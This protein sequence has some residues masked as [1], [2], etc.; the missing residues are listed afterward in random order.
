MTF[1]G[2]TALLAAPG[3]GWSIDYVVYETTHPDLVLL[4]I[5]P[6][7]TYIAGV[8]KNLKPDD[9]LP[10]EDTYGSNFYYDDGSCD[11]Q[12]EQMFFELKRDTWMDD[13][14]AYVSDD[15]EVPEEKRP[16]VAVGN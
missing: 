5:S 8:I 16:T 9:N 2:T 4:T 7:D 10:V 3:L 13:V 1:S 12:E 15:H 6:N 11:V 14:L